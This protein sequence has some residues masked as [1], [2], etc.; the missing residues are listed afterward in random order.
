MFAKI[1]EHE[2]HSFQIDRLA[3]FNNSIITLEEANI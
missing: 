2:E 1:V 3:Y